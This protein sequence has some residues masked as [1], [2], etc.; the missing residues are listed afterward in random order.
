MDAPNGESRPN[1]HAALVEESSQRPR[2]IASAFRG[3]NQCPVAHLR[4]G[5]SLGAGSESGEPDER[6]DRLGLLVDDIEVYEP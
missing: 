2:R 3:R 1:H 5:Q 4:H 6:D